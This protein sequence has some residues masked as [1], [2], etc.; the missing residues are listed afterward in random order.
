L[1]EMSLDEC[2]DFA[3]RLTAFCK[4]QTEVIDSTSARA[5]SGS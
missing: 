2:V 4:G 5:L 1:L 3:D